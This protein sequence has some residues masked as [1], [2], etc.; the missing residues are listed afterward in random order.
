[1]KHLTIKTTDP[2]LDL[3]LDLSS[4]NMFAGSNESGKSFINKSIFLG[5]IFSMLKT[6]GVPENYL[7]EAIDGVFEPRFVGSIELEYEKGAKLHISREED[8]DYKYHFE[9]LDKLVP[10]RSI[11]L[12]SFTR[13]FLGIEDCIKNPLEHKLYDSTFA[14]YFVDK[15]VVEITANIENLKKYKRVIYNKDTGKFTVEMED[16][17]IKI[18]SSLSNGI[19]ALI[20]MSCANQ[21]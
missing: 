7:Q 19:Q 20:I 4:L 14:Y 17:S 10:I 12:S 6:H 8:E 9:N 1:M 5:S 3:S 21:F 2:S 16:G 18:A 13:S 15:G 11:Y